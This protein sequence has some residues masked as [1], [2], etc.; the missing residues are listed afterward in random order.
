[1]F[2]IVTLVLLFSLCIKSH[3]HYD[4]S[5]T[6]GLANY[7]D[8]VPEDERLE[9]LRTEQYYRK[10]FGCQVLTEEQLTRMETA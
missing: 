3:N 5:L 8:A 7:Y 10:N 2:F 6:E 1:M 4:F 9:M